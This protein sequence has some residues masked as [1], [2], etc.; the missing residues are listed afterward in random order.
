M[1]G[2][3]TGGTFSAGRAQTGNITPLNKELYLNKLGKKFPSVYMWFHVEE[4]AL[5]NSCIKPTKFQQSNNSMYGFE[6][7]K[8]NL[9]FLTNKLDKNDKRHEVY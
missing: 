2:A 8:K 3:P 5:F 9:Y 4:M 7:H 6:I 1:E